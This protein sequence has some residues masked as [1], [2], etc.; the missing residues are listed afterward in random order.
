MFLLNKRPFISASSASIQPRVTWCIQLYRSTPAFPP[1]TGGVQATWVCGRQCNG[2]GKRAWTDE[3][4]SWAA[5]YGDDGISSKEISITPQRSF[6]R[7][8][9]SRMLSGKFRRRLLVIRNVGNGGSLF[10]PLI[11][12]ES[13]TLCSSTASL[14]CTHTPLY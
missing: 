6:S 8:A 12:C 5:V 11:L 1:T 10:A 4:W 9:P 3:G 13:L 7:V 2:R 14:S